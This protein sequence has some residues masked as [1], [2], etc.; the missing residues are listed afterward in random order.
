MQRECELCCYPPGWQQMSVR[1][2][3]H[4]SWSPSISS[5]PA[6]HTPADVQTHTHRMLQM[7]LIITSLCLS[8]LRVILPLERAL[9][10]EWGTRCRFPHC[11][12]NRWWVRC[13]FWILHTNVCTASQSNCGCH[14]TAAVE[15][16]RIQILDYIRKAQKMDCKA[17]CILTCLW[18]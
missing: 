8:K 17:S 12:C 5:P 2:R 4:T 16:N 9:Q 15:I 3:Q 14:N 1:S 7:Y 13:G 6:L 11:I 18:T 10:D